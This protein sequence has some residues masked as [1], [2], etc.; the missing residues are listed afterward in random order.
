MTLS[1]IRSGITYK[2]PPITEAVIEFR[3]AQ[4]LDLPTVEKARDGFSKEFSIVAKLEQLEWQFSGDPVHSSLN[5]STAGYRLHNADSTEIVVITAFSLSFS[6]VAPY[7]GWAAFSDSAMKIYGR[8]RELIGY[9]Q[10][11]RLGVRYINRLDGKF[12]YS[13]LIP[14]NDHRF[15]WHYR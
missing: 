11:F 3:F 10:I 2:Q 6:R 8:F 13:Q 12:V 4:A 5:T 15:S 1:G 14:E 9:T 7:S